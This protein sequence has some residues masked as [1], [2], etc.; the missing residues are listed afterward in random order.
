MDP[1]TSPIH[2]IVIGDT[3]GAKS[4]GL[5]DMAAL[6]GAMQ[7]KQN[8]GMDAAMLAALGG[9]NNGGGLF[10]GNGGGLLPLLIG[11]FLFGGRGGLLGGAGVGPA[12]AGAFAAESVAAQS[13]FTPKDTSLQLS[14]FQ[15]WAQSNATALATQLA[16]IDKS[17]CCSSRDIIA[18]V[19][20]LTPQVFQSFA[21]QSTQM[22]TG[23]NNVTSEINGMEGELQNHIAE[24]RNAVSAGFFNVEKTLDSG[25]AATA[26]ANCQTQNLIQSTGCDVKTSSLQSFAAMAQQLAACCCENRLAVANQNALIE[27]NTA[28]INAQS[29]SQYAALANQLNM[30]TCEIKQAISADGQATR[31]LIQ[32]NELDAL[33]TELA[34]AKA[35]LRGGSVAPVPVSN[36]VNITDIATAIAR[37]VGTQTRSA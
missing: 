12:G 21:A 3:S 13:I 6:L 16:G 18:A 28:A 23:F 30:Q 26:L 9:G 20:A 22:L 14:S 27:R 7:T 33:R 10:G 24:A 2:K 25:F 17:L 37:A 8:T 11:A 4:P 15:N 31:A 34:D 36:V 32:A 5:G 29:A 1:T 35:A 19:N